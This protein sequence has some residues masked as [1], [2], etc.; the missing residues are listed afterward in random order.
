MLMYGNDD[1]VGSSVST[2][3]K[4]KNAE[5]TNVPWRV[6]V[7]HS[8]RY[9][10][11]LMIFNI[12]SHEQSYADFVSYLNKNRFKVYDN[13]VVVIADSRLAKLCI[14]LLYVE[15]AIVLTDKSPLRDFGRLTTLTGG[16]WNP[17]LFRSQKRLSDREQQVLSLLV[18]GYS[19]N[20]ISDLIRVSY[21]TV[22]THKMRIIARLGLA[23]SAE[24][25]KLIVRFNHPLSFLS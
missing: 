11:R 13:A 12:I 15:K 1:F 5:I 2:Y 21:K 24:L 19:P 6:M 16:C 9:R 4:S 22:Q 10:H 18:S 20:E 17:R 23:H 8:A 14:E 25:N 7:D 3:L